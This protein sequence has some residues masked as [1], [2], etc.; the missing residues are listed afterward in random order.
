MTATFSLAQ[1]GQAARTDWHTRIEATDGGHLI[2]KPDAPVLLT[3]FVSYTCGSCARFAVE[4][5]PIIE[6]S[7]I[8]PGIVRLE[9]RPVIR[10]TTDLTVTML[11]QCGDASNFKKNHEYFIRTHSDWLVKAR[12]APQTQ[13]AIWNRGDVNARL[14]M[15]R[16]LDLDDKMVKRG[17]SIQE[18][19]ACL[20]DESVADALIASTEADKIKFGVHSTPSFAIN[21]KTV[22]EVHSWG[23]LFPKLAQ[24]VSDAA[25][26]PE[27]E[28]PD[29]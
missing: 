26:K 27:S 17:Y 20:K 25:P 23:G 1:N 3:E 18:V 19:N 9:V 12:N 28:L 5:D 24:V 14:N 8:M 13:Q 4:G 15:A 22:T 29:V 7:Y 16:A 11:A 6:F 21:G 2:G 10:N